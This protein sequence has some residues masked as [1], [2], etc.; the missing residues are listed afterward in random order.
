[1]LGFPLI[2]LSIK[3]ANIFT[4]G[5]K[6]WKTAA[7][8]MTA[9]EGTFE[10][11]FQLI[12]Q[13]F[14]VFNRA[15]REPTN[16]QMMTLA[17]SLLSCAVSSIEDIFAHK[18]ETSIEVK[19]S[20]IPY[21]LSSNI[22]GKMAMAIIISTTQWSMIFFFII[23]GIGYLIIIKCFRNMADTKKEL[24]ILLLNFCLYTITLTVI[25]IFVT[26]FENTSI[27]NLW[28]FSSVKLSDLAIVQKAYFNYI[29]ASCLLCGIISNVLYYYQVI[30]VQEK[31]E[32][33]NKEKESDA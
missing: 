12:L 26:Y 9:I 30:P 10:G 14:I 1:M 23:F 33:A 22:Y 13:L 15:D 27:W 32:E 20:F 18:P 3:F 2:F 28:I 8:A 11:G 19:A 25:A 24:I 7:M 31:E 17:S 16:I 21:A 29:F 5:Q 6:N 4:D